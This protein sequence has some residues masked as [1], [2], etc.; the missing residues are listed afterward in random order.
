MYLDQ[1]FDCPWEF[2][3]ESNA[4]NLN[5]DSL[6]QLLDG[7]ATAGGLVGKPLLVLLVHVGEQRHVGQEDVNLDDP[8]DGG[9]GGCEDSLQ[10]GN[11]DCCLLANGTFHKI[12][13]GVTGNLARAVNGGWRLDGVG[14]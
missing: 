14:L 9:T 5:V 2:L 1:A 4:L 13:I 12:A 6:G 10:V 7:H 8:L 3:R 11:A